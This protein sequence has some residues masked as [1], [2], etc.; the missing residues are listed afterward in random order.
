M[1]IC[2]LYSKFRV[3]RN[4]SRVTPY[5][6]KTFNVVNAIKAAAA[7]VKNT[8]VYD[9]VRDLSLIAREFKIHKHCY[10]DFTHEFTSGI[11]SVKKDSALQFSSS[12]YI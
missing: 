5:S 1:F 7:T 3:S 6:I 10:Q 9:E 8:K 12:S 2:N 11:A 4:S